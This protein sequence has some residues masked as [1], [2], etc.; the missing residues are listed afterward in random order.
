MQLIWVIKKEM[1]ILFPVATI[2]ITKLCPQ[3]MDL[4]FLNHVRRGSMYSLMIDSEIEGATQHFYK[5][6]SCACNDWKYILEL[7][8]YYIHSWLS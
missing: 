5:V 6:E 1:W 7:V 8:P 3:L 4:M 2:H